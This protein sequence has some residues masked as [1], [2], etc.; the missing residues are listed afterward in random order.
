M[1]EKDQAEFDRILSLS[2]TQ[3][4]QDDINFLNA[5]RSYLTDAQRED[6]KLVIRP[7]GTPEPGAEVIGDEEPEKPAKA[8]KDEGKVEVELAPAPQEEDTKEDV[9]AEVDKSKK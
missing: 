2:T 7:E 5:R 8:K 9:F 3:M 6:F 1:N 4:T